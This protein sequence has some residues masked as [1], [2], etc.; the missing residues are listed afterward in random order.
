MSASKKVIAA[1][2]A[3]MSC[4]RSALEDAGQNSWS[5]GLQPA[6]SAIFGAKPSATRRSDLSALPSNFFALRPAL[7]CGSE[8]ICATAATGYVSTMDWQKI[9]ALAVV[10]GTVGVF[11]TRAWPHRRKFSF[12]RQTHCGCGSAALA[13][14][15]HSVVF[16]ARKGERA[17]V[18]V[19]MK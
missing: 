15:G 13:A 12:E 9:A 7:E 10:A 2:A 14:A 18:I 4:A 1:R 17:R 11:L 8:T 5:A 16:H 6:F 19:K 3:H